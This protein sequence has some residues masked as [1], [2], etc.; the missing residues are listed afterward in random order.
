MPGSCVRLGEG[1]GPEALGDGSGRE[2]KKRNNPPLVS[3]AAFEVYK[4][5]WS[6]SWSVSQAP[7]V[8]ATPPRLLS[9]LA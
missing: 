7:A 2:R 3:S 8:R 1:L 6:L 5:R 9:V 4:G